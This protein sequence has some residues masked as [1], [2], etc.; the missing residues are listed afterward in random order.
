MKRPVKLN[1]GGKSQDE[2]SYEL[3]AEL[4]EKI[5]GRFP[6]IQLEVEPRETVHFVTNYDWISLLLEVG[7]LA[8]ILYFVGWIIVPSRWLMMT[9]LNSQIGK[10]QKRTDQAPRHHDNQLS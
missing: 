9:A 1:I 3:K 4:G 6:K 10:V 2:I 5:E 7:S 8:L